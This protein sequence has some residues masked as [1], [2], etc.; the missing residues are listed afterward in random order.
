MQTLILCGGQGTRG[1]PQT[2]FVPKPLL[3]VGDRPILRHVMEIYAAQG[4]RDFLL[5]AGYLIEQIEAFAETTP[6]GWCVEVIDTGAEADTGE[7]V[8]RCRAVLGD[9]FFLT[10]GDG[11][12]DVDLDALLAFHRDHGGAATLTV[13]PLPSQYGTVDVRADGRIERFREKPV[14]HDHL[15]NAGFMVIEQRAFEWWVGPN[16]ERDV[17][18]ALSDAGEVYAYLHPGFWRSMDTH[19]DATELS[20]LC[21]AGDPPWRPRRSA[22][23][24]DIPDGTS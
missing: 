5:A 18:P 9:R 3:G 7:R 17:L 15:I 1:Q 2:T 14:L 13:V 24:D 23:L 21:A 11:V 16:L 20:A 6:A 4:F 12:G 22:A 19:K 10:Y 8:A